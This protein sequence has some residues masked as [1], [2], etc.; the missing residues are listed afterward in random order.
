M[1]RRLV[2]TLVWGFASHA[3][4]TCLYKGALNSQTRSDCLNMS[5]LVVN[6]G[7]RPNISVGDF[8]AGPEMANAIPNNTEI[9]CLYVPRRQKGGSPKFRCLWSD[10][11]FLRNKHGDVIQGAV[12]VLPDEKT[13]IDSDGQVIRDDDGDIQ[14]ADKIRFK[15]HRGS[16]RHN[17]VF[18]EVLAT[19]LM[20]YLGFA[21][22]TV[23]PAST[24]CA[25]CSADPHGR[26]QRTR[27]DEVH[28]FAPTSV[29]RKFD[30]KGVELYSDQG[31][32][33]NELISRFQGQRRI[34][35][36]A[37]ALALRLINYRNYPNFQNQISCPRGYY[38][39]RTGVCRRAVV[40]VQDV[41]N[42]FGALK[43]SG[44]YNHRGEYLKYAQTSQRI[45]M[46]PKAESNDC[47]LR[48]SF[49]SL[50]K[51]TEPARRYIADRLGGLSYEHIR[52]LVYLAFQ[53][54][55][56]DDLY[57]QVDSDRWAE[58]IFRRMNQI[59][60]RRCR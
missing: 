4:A 56:H 57:G 36:E 55:F 51:V 59:I 39:K 53:Y 10:G 44:P 48:Y 31:W 5:E 45:F 54:E 33:F 17:E 12:D 30:G 7:L 40:Y 15:Y 21:T 13:L 38:D 41:G 49:Y 43:T 20:W 14:E 37:Y 60:E 47:T 19:R 58:V 26:D 32:D 50:T 25:G 1:V 34:D 24:V 22:D 2:L 29:E 8:L 9:S 6:R 27:V 18:T 52:A 35:L 46:D 28:R 42:T 23:Y 16:P 3:D 11:V